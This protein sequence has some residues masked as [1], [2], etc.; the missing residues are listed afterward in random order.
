VRSIVGKDDEQIKSL[1]KNAAI[2]SEDQRVPMKVF[3]PLH[4][5]AG[6]Q[7]EAPAVTIALVKRWLSVLI[8][9]SLMLELVRGS[10]QLHDI[11]R[12]VCPVI[13]CSFVNIL[14]PSA[15]G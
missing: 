10:I 5:A 14:L 8:K 4:L 3:L 6:E 12:M 2:F 13:L 7:V 11:V 15:L 9:R 1:F